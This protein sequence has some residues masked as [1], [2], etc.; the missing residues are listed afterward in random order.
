MRLKGLTGDSGG[1]PTYLANGSTWWPVISLKLRS[2]LV[3]QY[4]VTDYGVLICFYQL[5]LEE[6]F[7]WSF[8]L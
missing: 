1:E 6:P 5:Q 3:K 2:D 7:A 4:C 8:W